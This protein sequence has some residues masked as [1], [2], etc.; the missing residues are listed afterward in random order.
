M[1]KKQKGY[2]SV[3]TL[4]HNAFE[5]FNADAIIDKMMKSSKWTESQY[6]GMTKQEIKNQWK[7]TAQ[8]QQQWEQ[9]WI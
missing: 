5:K 6:Y 9:Q 3:T 1:L 2:T 8:R 7:K 4:I